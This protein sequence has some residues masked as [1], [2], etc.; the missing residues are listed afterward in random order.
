[1]NS[2]DQIGPTLAA[3]A[4]EAQR[5][6]DAAGRGVDGSVIVYQ[7]GGEVA[8]DNACSL[9]W[10]RVVRIDGVM[11]TPK[12][13]GEPCN[14]SFWDV[15]LGFGVIRCIKGLSGPKGTVF[16]TPGQINDDGAGM[17]A[18][19][20]TLRD[21]VLSIHTP[22]VMVWQPAGPQGDRAGGEW[23]LGYRIMACAPAEV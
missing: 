11:G 6:L 19:L 17:L 4:V 7:P 16:P 20:A 12:A 3:Y 23:I 22:R 1:M 15:Q 10:G 8:W 21:A 18:D 14:V 13:D 2:T 9:L 5:R